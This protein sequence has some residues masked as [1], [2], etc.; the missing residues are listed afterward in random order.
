M[1]TKI[2]KIMVV[3]TVWTL[4]WTTWAGVIT[5]EKVTVSVQPIGQNAFQLL[6]KFDMPQFL[7]KVNIDHAV[8]RFGVNI[9]NPPDGK[10]LEI[11]SADSTSQGA[12]VNYNTNPVTGFIPKNKIGLTQIELDVTQLVDLWVNGGAKNDGILVISHRRISE[13]AL[14]TNKVTLATG[15]MKPAVAVFYTEVEE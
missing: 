5:V 13:Q 2:L 14:Q 1:S 15:V 10:L 7:G 11:L 4:P 6:F 9:V 3:L 12:V 8:L